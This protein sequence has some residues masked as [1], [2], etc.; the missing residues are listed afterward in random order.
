M[1]EL[2]FSISS[3]EKFFG[4]KH[5]IEVFHFSVNHKQQNVMKINI[6]HEST[7]DKERTV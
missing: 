3:L 2:S 6:S 1:G 7:E 4:P 5:Q